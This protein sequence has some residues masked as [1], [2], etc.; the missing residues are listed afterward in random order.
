MSS[1]QPIDGNGRDETTVNMLVRWAIDRLAALGASS[2]S[3]AFELLRGVAGIDRAA[4][5]AHAER[6]VDDAIATSFRSAV[7]RRRAGEPVAYITGRRGFHALELGVGPSV[8]VPRPESEILVDEVLARAPAGRRFTVLDLG[9]G[10]GAV[11][12]AIAA[13]RRDALVVG[14]DLSRAALDTARMNAATL[15]LEVRW[16]ESNWYTALRGERFDFI[17]CN[18]PYVRRDDAHMRALAHEPRLALDGGADGLDSIQTVLRDAREHLAPGGWLMLEHAYD[19]APEVARLA[20]SAGL[21]V[22]R[23]VRDLAGH[24]RVTVMSID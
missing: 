1:V 23:L 12:L 19:Q 24:D 7:E 11:A 17:V 16:I 14:V 10:S 8:L 3:D 22:E 2:R 5:Y 13:A 9:T 18:P 6:V 15:G 4:V 21:E 20:E